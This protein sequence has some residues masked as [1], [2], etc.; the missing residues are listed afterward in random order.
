MLTRLVPVAVAGV[1]ALALS[2]CTASPPSAQSTTPTSSASGSADLLTPQGTTLTL[3]ATAR[4]DYKPDE[5]RETTLAIT[6]SKVTLA[7]VSDFVL[8]NLNATQRK[9]NFYYVEMKIDNVGNGTVGGDLVPVWGVSPADVL[10]PPVSFSS[11]FKPCTSKPLP[12]TFA[13][14]DSLTFCEVYQVKKSGELKAL[15]Y[16]PNQS[17][18]PI[19]WSP[20]TL[21]KS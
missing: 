13:P 2:G 3:G 9:S 4:V 10:L 5:V 16:R 14:G 11:R 18:N 19:V 17:F 8:F 1:L 21:S 12:Q 15:S 7:Q 6:V 20:I